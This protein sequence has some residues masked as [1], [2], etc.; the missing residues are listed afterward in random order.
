MRQKADLAATLL[1]SLSHD[2]RTP[3]TAIRVAVENLRGELPTDG[4][5]RAGAARPSPKLDRLTRLFQDILD[6][7]RID[8]AGD[9]HR[10]A[11]GH[12]GRRRRCGD[13]PTCGMRS[14]DTRCASTPMPSCEVEIDPRL[15]S[16]ALSHVLENA[17]HYSPADREIVVRGHASRP[18][19]C[20]CR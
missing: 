5:S 18:M 17:A 1:A 8:A 9:P 19:V 7:A 20:T 13:A 16:V 4:T 15:T 12:G 14:R 11:V 6:M 2:L 10:P 3:L